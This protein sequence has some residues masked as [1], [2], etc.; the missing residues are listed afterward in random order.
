[1]GET[2]IIERIPISHRQRKWIRAVTKDHKTIKNKLSPKIEF[3]HFIKLKLSPMEKRRER[4]IKKRI[5]DL[6]Y[7]WKNKA[8]IN[9]RH[10]INYKIFK[11]D[12]NTK[13]I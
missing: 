12:S 5:Y 9:R 7:Y 4:Q 10:R 1:M 13:F 3:K 2:I 11:E 8:E 6:D